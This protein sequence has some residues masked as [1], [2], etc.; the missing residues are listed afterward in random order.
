MQIQTIFSSYSFG[1][2]VTSYH[3]LSGISQTQYTCS[4]LHSYCLPANFIPFLSSFRIID[5]L[6]PNVSLLQNVPKSRMIITCTPK[7]ALI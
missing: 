5:Q 6:S 4:G 2:L 3:S 1:L 7:A